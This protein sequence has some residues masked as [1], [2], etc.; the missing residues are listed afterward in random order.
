MNNQPDH[1]PAPQSG[2]LTPAPD[3]REQVASVTRQQLDTIYQT[4]PP[5]QLK[6]DQNPYHRTHT[7]NFDWRTYHSA[8]QNYYQQYYHRYY[9]QQIAS[10][11]QKNQPHINQVV[12]G[13]ETG[14]QSTFTQLRANIRSAASE[15][16]QKFRKSHHF[17]P[18]VSAL[19]V[20]LIF[21]FLQ[22]NSIL[23]ANVKAYVS[24]G[25]F[26]EESAAAID[27]SAAVAVGPDARLIIP[28]IN[29]DVPVDYTVTTLNEKQIL[30]S[31]GDSAV[32]YKLPGA[33]AVP[34]QFGNTVILGHSGN[35]IFSHGQYKF[36]FVLLDKMVAGDTFYMHYQGKQYV[37]KVTEI[38]II[39]PNQVNA[40][41]IGNSKAMV[42]L[43]TCTPPGSAIQRRLVFAEQ[44]SPDPS[45]AMAANN[46]QTSAETTIPGTSPTLLD[47]F[48]DLFF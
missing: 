15:R 34:G 48:W 42:T 9:T 45:S 26:S 14:D 7:E 30:D 1:T 20:G 41:H 2:G 36:V 29:V 24:P 44:I 5:N 23:F 10:Q 8:W 31:L 43:V 27:P 39:N 25:Q 33:D 46:D 22:F 28:K 21:L 37:Y 18:I 12:T 47:Q 40:L 38:K 16:A 11:H 4:N 6:T 13:A 32:H 3:N 35:D 19:A 17:I